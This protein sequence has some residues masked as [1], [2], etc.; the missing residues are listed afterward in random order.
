MAINNLFQKCR[1]DQTLDSIGYT[2]FNINDI[3]LNIEG[4][5][6]INTNDKNRLN[7]SLTSLNNIININKYNDSKLFKNSSLEDV[8]KLEELMNII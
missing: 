6:D 3:N 8:D 5:N 7:K 1:D 2:N 4:Y